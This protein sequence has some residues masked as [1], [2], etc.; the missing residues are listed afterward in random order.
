MPAPL[1]APTTPAKDE[2]A[3]ETKE[4][5]KDPKKVEKKKDEPKENKSTPP[6]VSP[7]VK[8]ADKPARE[9]ALPNRTDRAAA[10]AEDADASFTHT[11]HAEPGPAPP[12]NPPKV[13]ADRDKPADQPS[14]DGKGK[15]KGDEKKGDE[16]PTGKGGDKAAPAAS[17]VTEAMFKEEVKRAEERD[18]A[19]EA[20]RKEEAKKAEDREKAAEARHKAL[21]EAVAKIATGVA[22]LLETDDLEPAN[23]K[24]AKEAVTKRRADKA[25]LAKKMDEFLQNILK[26]TNALK[27]ISDVEAKEPG[28]APMV[29]TILETYKQSGVEQS[30][31][32]KDLGQNVMDHNSNQHKLTQDAAKQW[33]REQVGFNLAG[34]LDDFCKSIAGEVRSLLKEVGDLREQRRAMYM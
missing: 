14:E 15:G 29:K 30:K 11:V 34:Y 25:T 20:R 24:K 18:K 7:A 33:A 3:D 26:D 16:K 32:L 22:A 21:L 28:K 9:C 31:W 23:V 5:K 19:A 10:P 4:E 2:R 8:S 27:K 1:A 12:P 17:G 6:A 13:G